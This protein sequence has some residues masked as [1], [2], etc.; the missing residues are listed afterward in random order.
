MWFNKDVDKPDQIK[1]H[2]LPVRAGFWDAASKK[3]DGSKAV[4]A[5]LGL[6]DVRTVLVAGGGDGVGGL[7]RV[8]VSVGENLG[9]LEGPTQ[10]GDVNVVVHGFV[11]NMDEWMIASDC[12]AGP[13]TI[14][15]ASI[16]GLPTMLSGFLPGQE[17]GNVPYVINAGFGDFSKEPKK[18]GETVAHWLS[19][20]DALTEMSRKATEVGRRH[21]RAT[22]EIAV[23]IASLLT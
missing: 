2:G 15:E 4:K 12:L 5:K 17:A 8:A 6:K 9:T 21:A 23:E 10:M 20:E 1:K 14:A 7:Q 11:S 16:V 13:G 3:K 19:T 18:I 22:K